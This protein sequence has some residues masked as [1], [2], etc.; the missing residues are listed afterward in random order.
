MRLR[1]ETKR[2][3]PALGDTM[4]TDLQGSPSGKTYMTALKKKM[5]P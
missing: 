3:I 2:R 1:D 5:A 4:V